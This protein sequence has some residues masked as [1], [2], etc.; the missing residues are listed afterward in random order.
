VKNQLILS[1]PHDPLKILMDAVFGKDNFRNETV[2]CYKGPAN[3]KNHFPRKHDRILFYGRSKKAIFY[4]DTVRI[5][6]SE[7]FM[8]RRKHTECE[9]GITGGYSES[10][11]D[12]EVKDKFGKGKLLKIF[13][14]IFLLAGKYLKQNAPAIRRKNRLRF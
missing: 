14:L 7:S 1:A 10:R 4:R 13:G 11:T 2:W 6:Y 5:P 8:Q 3:V 12:E 9:S